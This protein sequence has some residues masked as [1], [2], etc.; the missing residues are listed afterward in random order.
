MNLAEQGIGGHSTPEAMVV[1]G[2][3]VSSASTSGLPAQP[4]AHHPAPAHPPA[5]IQAAPIDPTARAREALVRESRALY[6]RSCALLEEAEG[7]VREARHYDGT[8]ERSDWIKA[9]ASALQASSSVAKQVQGF[10][11]L[12]AKLEGLLR[13]GTQV[14]VAVAYVQSP[15]WRRLKRALLSALEPHPEA[16]EAV[17]R[18]LEGLE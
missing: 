3:V 4:P 9:R 16:L 1:E 11:E 17:A 15:E 18:A 14:N 8:M 2:E 12:L 13:T 6:R 10:A 7:L 5:T